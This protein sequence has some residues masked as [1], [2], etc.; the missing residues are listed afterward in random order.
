MANHPHL[1]GH[2]VWLT[3]SVTERKLDGKCTR[4]AN[5]LC[6]KRHHRHQHSGESSG[7]ERSCQHGHVNSAVWSRGGQQHTVRAIHLQLLGE[8]WS[9]RVAP[10][11]TIRWK[12]LVAHERIGVLR[13]AAD[14]TFLGKCLKA[15][16]RQ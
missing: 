11:G 9:E 16:H 6:P 1:L 4:H 8:L 15:M 5:L 10:G 12:T 2:I 7:L 13:Q 14:R 3:K